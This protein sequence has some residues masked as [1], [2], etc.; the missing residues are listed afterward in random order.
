MPF[1]VQLPNMKVLIVGTGPMAMAYGNV[2]TAI[3]IPFEVVG[4][5]KASCDHFFQQTGWPAVPGG[6]D[7]LRIQNNITKFSHAIIA[8]SVDQLSSVLFKVLTIG[9]ETVL[10]EKPAALRIADFDEMQHWSLNI[11]NVFVAY[12]RR[13][14]SSVIET[15][16]LINEDGGLQNIHFEFTEWVHK[17]KIEDKSPDILANWFLANSSH[18]VDLAFFLGGNP[19]D[20]HACS[21]SG[22]LNWHEKIRFAGSGITEKDIL[23]TYMSNWE[24]AGRWSLELLT[25]KRR[26]YLRPL[27]AIDIQMKGSLQLHTHEFDHSLD[28]QF[29]PGLY[30]QV[31]SFLEGSFGRMITL[32]EQINRVRTVYSKML[33]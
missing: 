15:E 28:V 13:F 31:K 32:P 27:E 4:R 17:I 12:N 16:R 2:L 7:D 11:D 10:I 30:L 20:W 6:I 22:N 8:V 29:K 5:S 3:N 9:I 24:S 14:Y 25:N 26:I 18:V 21:R 23:F 33:G 19:I 1:N